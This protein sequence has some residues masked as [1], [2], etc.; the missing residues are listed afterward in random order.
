VSPTRRSLLAIGAV[1][2]LGAGVVTVIL[3]LGVRRVPEF[4]S[5]TDHPDPALHGTVAYV[6]TTSRDGGRW[7]V[8]LV[9]ASGAA[10]K[11]IECRE[12]YGSPTLAWQEDGRLALTSTYPPLSRTVV[13][14]ATGAT[15]AVAT[16]PND[17]ADAYKMGGAFPPLVLLDTSPSGERAFTWSDRGKAHLAIDGPGGER[18]LLSVTGP[19]PYAFVSTPVWAPDWSWILVQDSEGR[20]LLVTPTEPAHTAILAT[21]LDRAC[22][23]AITEACL[24][25]TSADLLPVP[26]G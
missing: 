22:A 24:A 6:S 18:E 15:E 26:G 5:L 3:A 4:P 17:P 21:G 9:S 1:L 14:V 8:N 11:E 13:D 19:E 10:A 16:D 23:M 12:G 25:V 7:C 2:V 20:L